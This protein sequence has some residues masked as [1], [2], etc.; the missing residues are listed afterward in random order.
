MTVQELAARLSLPRRSR[1]AALA[2]PLSGAEEQ[3]WRCL[4]ARDQ[5][6]FEEELSRREAPERLALALYLRWGVRTYEEYRGRGIPDAVFWDTFH[7]FALWSKE[8]ERATGRP[9]LTEWGWNAL[10]LRME[11][12]RLGRLEYQPHTLDRGIILG[13]VSLAA[14]TPVLEVHI[15]AGTRLRRDD[16]LSSLNAAGAFFQRYFA[17]GA[18]FQRYFQR[19]FLWFHCHSWLLSPELRELL[20]AESGILQFQHLFTVYDE[21]F[22]IRQAEERVFGTVE[23]DPREYPENTSLQR[24]LKTYLLEGKCVGM[25]KGIRR[26]AVSAL[27][28]Q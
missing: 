5:Q 23:Q 7:D 11:V 4:F 8:C 3:A 22:P 15:P 2:V 19:D 26:T 27:D 6:A 25:G 10:L 20:T 28:S 16:L 1:E 21:D 17:A 13:D 9:G 24:A 12:V 14:G 18:F